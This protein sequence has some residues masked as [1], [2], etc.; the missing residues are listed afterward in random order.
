MLQNCEVSIHRRPVALLSP[1]GFLL[2]DFHQRF[3]PLV[4][5]GVSPIAACFNGYL[6]QSGYRLGGVGSLIVWAFSS[7]RVTILA[8]S[9]KSFESVIKKGSEACHREVINL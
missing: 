8:V 1:P 6:P 9:L 3:H 2:G 4:V 5:F 7:R